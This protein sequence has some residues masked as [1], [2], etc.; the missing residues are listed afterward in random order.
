MQFYKDVLVIYMPLL[1]PFSQLIAIR[2]TDF[3]NHSTFTTDN[4][5]RFP[6]TGCLF[7]IQ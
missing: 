6:V 5:E 7:F 3:S 1:N 2:D 4:A